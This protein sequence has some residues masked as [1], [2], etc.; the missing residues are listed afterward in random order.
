MLSPQDVGGWTLTCNPNTWD[1]RDFLAAGGGRIDGWSVQPSYRLGL[2]EPGQPVYLW[3]TKGAADIDSG[4]WARGCVVERPQRDVP[5]W[6]WLDHEKARRTDTFL[7]LDLHLFELLVPRDHVRGTR[8][9]EDLEILRSPQMSNPQVVR[10]AEV[11]L[12]DGLIGPLAD[13]RPRRRA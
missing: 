9:L 5:D 3:V 10:P 11:A 12:L 7:P 6:R 8:G 13:G 1:L 4:V 2:I